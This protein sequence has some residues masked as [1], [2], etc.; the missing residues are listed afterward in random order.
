V[1]SGGGFSASYPD[2]P[3]PYPH[4]C[5]SMVLPNGLKSSAL[6]LIFFMGQGEERHQHTVLL[7]DGGDQRVQYGVEDGLQD[8]QGHR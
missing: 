2:L 7:T 3:F 5:T 1:G 4:L 6:W 8:W